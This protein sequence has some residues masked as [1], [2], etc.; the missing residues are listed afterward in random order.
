MAGVDP[1]ST[2]LA[3]VKSAPVM[4][5]VVPP[6]GNPPSGTDRADYRR[7]Y[8]GELVGSRRRRRST[9]SGDGDVDGP[10]A[11]RADSGHLSGRDHVTLVAA[12]YPKSTIGGAGEVGPGDRDR[13][14]TAFDP[15]VGL[16]E[17]TV[18]ALSA[19]TT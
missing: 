16:V 3:L 4:V 15:D 5:T 7:R 13:R 12:V 18:G 11:C 2:A 8:I 1:K 6:A 9:E 10:R 14:A 17:L 19:V